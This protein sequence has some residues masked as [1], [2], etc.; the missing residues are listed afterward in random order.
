MGKFKAFREIQHPGSRLGKKW[1]GRELLT[2]QIVCGASGA[3]R[4]AIPRMVQDLTLFSGIQARLT[5]PRVIEGAGRVEE[6]LLLRR[7][8]IPAHVHNRI[9]QFGPCVDIVEPDPGVIEIHRTVVT[10]VVMRDCISRVVLP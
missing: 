8:V 9:A 1:G 3:P 6:G 5:F 7:Y 4:L 2:I 10:L